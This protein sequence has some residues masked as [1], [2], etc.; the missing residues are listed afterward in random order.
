MEINS[1][2]RRMTDGGVAGLVV[3]ALRRIIRAIDLR[4]RH[5]VTHYGLTGPQLVVLRQLAASDG[6]P[7]GMLTRAV[8][9]SQATVTG[10]LDRL[11]KRGLV[12]RERSTGDR[13]RVLVW[14][15]QAGEQLLATAPPLLQEE[16]RAAFDRLEDWEQTQ[17][18]SSLQRVVSM[19]EAKD[20]EATPILTTGPAGVT[21]ERTKAFLDQKVRNAAR[22]AAGTES[23]A[24]PEGAA[25]ER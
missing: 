19:M 5:L 23:K 11:E 2:R 7:V 17:I 1:E 15:T 4:S 21:P 16:F 24:A 20:I 25:P 18:L 22:G 8:H 6:T 13:R 10:I 9:L 12:R 14:L 3:T